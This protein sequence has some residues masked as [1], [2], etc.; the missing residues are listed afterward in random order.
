MLAMWARKACIG[1]AK[2]YNKKELTS[3][4]IESLTFVFCS[5]ALLTE[6]NT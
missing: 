2:H 3:V 1:I 5:D 6:I 4:K